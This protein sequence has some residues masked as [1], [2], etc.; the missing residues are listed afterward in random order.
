[1]KAGLELDALVAE[2]VFGCKL[3]KIN[4]ALNETKDFTDYQRIRKLW[5]DPIKCGCED[6]AHN[7]IDQHGDNLGLK[8]YSSDNAAALEIAEKLNSIGFRIGITKDWTLEQIGKWV[9]CFRDSH[10]DNECKS[11]SLPRAICLAALRAVQK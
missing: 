9:V 6:S 3:W 5:T 7:E 4:E 1:M 10:A 8:R 11:D 2:R